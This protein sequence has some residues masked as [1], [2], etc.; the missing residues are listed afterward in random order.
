MHCAMDSDE[1]PDSGSDCTAG[2]GLMWQIRLDKR[3]VLALWRSASSYEWHEVLARA[4][5]KAGNK[6]V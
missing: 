4:F 2:E 6:Y 3:A 5:Q 1:R